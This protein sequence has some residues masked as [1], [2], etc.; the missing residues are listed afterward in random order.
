MHLGHGQSKVTNMVFNTFTVSTTGQQFLEN[1]SPA[2]IRVPSQTSSVSDKKTAS[3][4]E[5]STNSEPPTTKPMRKSKGMNLLPLL[6]KLL[7]SQTNWYQMTNESDH[8]F[9]G[10]FSLQ[11]PKHLGYCQDITT[12]LCIQVLMRTSSFLISS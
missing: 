2:L 12:F 3:S 11:Y 7:S 5:K 9:P 8:Q 6:R 4:Q 1:P 10:Y